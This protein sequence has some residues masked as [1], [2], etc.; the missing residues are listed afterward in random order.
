M[1]HHQ[2]WRAKS[3]H[4]IANK[5]FE[6]V[7]KFKYFGMTVTNQNCIHEEIKNRLVS[8]NAYYRSFQNFCLPAYLKICKAI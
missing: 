3:L 2:D 8:G 7:A 4:K 5:S 6:N 1:S